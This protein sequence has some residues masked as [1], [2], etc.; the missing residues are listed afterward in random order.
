[1]KPTSLFIKDKQSDPTESFLSI[2]DFGI[3]TLMK[4]ARTRTRITPGFFTYTA[5]EVID[6]Q[7]ADFK[8]DVWSIGAILFDMCTTSLLDA[9]EL[10]LNLKNMRHDDILIQKM[11]TLIEEVLRIMNH[12]TE[13]FIINFL[14]L[15]K[16]KKSFTIQDHCLK[17]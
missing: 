3:E 10:H 4:D 14:F 11:M 6:S 12:L 1:L 13:M 9:N 16:I 15:Y 8:S 17:F 5:P 7:L 2:G